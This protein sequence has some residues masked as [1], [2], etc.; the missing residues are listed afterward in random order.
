MLTFFYCYRHFRRCGM[1]LAE[2]IKRAGHVATQ[3]F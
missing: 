3:G 1:S 2:A